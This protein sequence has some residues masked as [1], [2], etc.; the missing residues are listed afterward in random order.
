MR[1]GHGQYMAGLSRGVQYMV[2]QP[3]RAAGVGKTGFQNG[4]HQRV[5][6]Q[7]VDSTRSGHD[8]AHHKH[9]RFQGQLIRAVTLDQFDAQGPQLVA[10]RGVNAGIATGDPVTGFAGQGGQTAHESPA[11]A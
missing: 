1:T 9:V 8:V 6:G 11:N 5:A 4:F 10:H 7:A 2:A 3:L